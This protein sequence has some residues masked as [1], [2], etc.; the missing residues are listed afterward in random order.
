MATADSS[1]RPN[2]IAVSCCKVVGKNKILVTDNFMNK[3]RNNL[4]ANPVA[5]CAV[6][7]PDREKGFQFK[8]KVRYLTSGKWKR[9]VEAMPENKNLAHKGAVLIEVREIWDLVNPRLLA[10]E[11]W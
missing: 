7:S 5:A 9:R 1:G 8:G 11:K 4:L 2:V 6:W 3:T 10:E